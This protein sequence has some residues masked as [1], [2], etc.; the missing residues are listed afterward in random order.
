VFAGRVLVFSTKSL[1]L[2]L[3]LDVLPA[4]RKAGQTLCVLV[5]RREWSLFMPGIRSKHF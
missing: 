4:S 2:P 3:L 1:L 5:R